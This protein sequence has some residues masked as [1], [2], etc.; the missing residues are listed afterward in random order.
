MVARLI[1]EVA[2]V[3]DVEPKIVVA[4]APTSKPGRLDQH[5]EDS[6]RA[7]ALVRVEEEVDTGAVSPTHIDN[8]H[9][10]KSIVQTVP[11]LQ[12]LATAMQKPGLVATLGHLAFVSS[13]PSLQ[14][15]AIVEIESLLRESGPT[16]FDT[17]VLVLAPDST[18][19]L[20]E[21]EVIHRNSYR[22]TCLARRTSGRIEHPT[23]PP[24][25]TLQ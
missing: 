4:P 24:I 3:F 20:G 1:G 11:H 12:G 14:L 19:R 10:D 7:S 18:L 2:T 23:Y 9:A 21:F 22:L 16:N 13:Q 15:M 17:K 8:A 6:E 5:R 25:S